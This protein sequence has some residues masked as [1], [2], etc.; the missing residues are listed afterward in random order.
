MCAFEFPPQWIRSLIQAIYVN[1]FIDTF[2]FDYTSLA[3]AAGLAVDAIGN[4]CI[5]GSF[6]LKLSKK[7]IK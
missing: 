6:V 5:S 7:K 4:E 2:C 3:Q 1:E